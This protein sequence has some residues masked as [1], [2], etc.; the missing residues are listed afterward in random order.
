MAADAVSQ[1]LPNLFEVIQG[2]G[3]GSV[4]RTSRPREAIPQRASVTG[5][6]YLD[7][8][9]LRIQASLSN[10]TGTVLHAT[11]P[12]IAPRSD[13]GKAV[14]LVRQRVLGAIAVWADP[15]VR[16]SLAR[17]PL[18]GAYREYKAAFTV[19]A[20][21][22]ATAIAHEGRAIEIDPTFFGA[23]YQMA[24]AYINL[25]D[26]RRAREV[27]ERTSAMGDRWTPKERALL[28]YLGHA[29]EGHL[30]DALVALREAQRSDQA[31]LSTNYLVGYYLVRLNR[32]QESIDKYS[33]IDADAWD[34]VTVGTWRYARLTT[35]NHLLGRHEEELHVARIARNLFPTS[36]LSRI[37]ELNA[38]A[39]LGRPDDV[40]RAINDLAAVGISGAS[41]TGQAMR[42]AAEELRAH[43]HRPESIE[44]AQRSVAWHRNRPSQF[45][46]VPANRFSLAQSLYVAEEWTEAAALTSALLK[47]QPGSVAYAGLAG[48]NA[49]RRG[50]RRLAQ[51]YAAALAQ[52]A[53][54]PGGASE[55]RRAQLAALLGQREQAV[56]FLR[57]AFARGLS[58]GTNVHRQMDF[59]A[60]RGFAP[61]DGLMKPKG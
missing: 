49:G 4:P 6:Y 2:G 10:T 14:D 54:D 20:D 60:L 36:M 26:P 35:A 59:E 8:Q 47:E 19:F 53:S 22:P 16:S 30:Q 28:T 46:S 51:T 7:G 58:M 43:G 38:L 23:Y 44:L 40:G 11:E 57:D 42:A 37:D 25:G 9:N 1:E 18:Y 39:A 55:L 24:L 34:K 52:A 45:L 32:P 50:D 12:A 5:A 61:F 3:T 13:P 29:T 56:A 21:D 33:K 17:P 15:D 31:D 48:A 27:V 41:T